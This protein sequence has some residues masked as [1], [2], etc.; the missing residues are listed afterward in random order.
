MRLSSPPWIPTSLPMH[1]PT[2][3]GH[4]WISFDLPDVQGCLD[5]DRRGSLQ[6]VE[7]SSHSWARHL[8][9]VSLAEHR[10]PADRDDPPY[11]RASGRDQRSQGFAVA[12][13]ACR[14]MAE[15]RDSLSCVGTAFARCGECVTGYSYPID[16]CQLSFS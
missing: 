15:C 3:A 1:F 6:E 2:A 8:L 13:I 9:A 11:R 14:R 7:R 12:E 16:Q 10:Q 4:L 5:V